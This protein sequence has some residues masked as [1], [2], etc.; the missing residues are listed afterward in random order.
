[1][2]QSRI[3]EELIEINA[4]LDG[5]L[6]ISGTV[7]ANAG[8]DLNTSLLALES[9]GNLADIKTSVELIDDTVATLGTN[10]YTEATTKGLIIGAVR[11]D[12]GGSLVDTDNEIA[13][14]QV[15]SNG[16]LIVSSGAGMNVIITDVAFTTTQ[17]DPLEMI[18]KRLNTDSLITNDRLRVQNMRLVFDSHFSIDDEPLVWSYNNISGTSATQTYDNANSTVNITT[19][20]LASKDEFVSKRPINISGGNVLCYITYRAWD[21]EPTGNQNRVMVGLGTQ[22]DG[23]FYE[24]RGNNVAEFFIR[25]NNVNVFSVSKGAW[26]IDAGN[27]PDDEQ[28][29]TVVFDFNPIVGRVR[30]GFLINGEISYKTEHFQDNMINEWP[31][32]NYLRA[33]LE[34][35]ADGLDPS[36]ITQLKEFKLFQED[37]CYI[38]PIYRSMFNTTTVALASGSTYAIAGIIFKAGLIKF[39]VVHIDSVGI[40]VTSASDEWLVSIQLDPTLAGAPAY[41]D[42]T[43]SSIRTL[44]LSNTHTVTGGTIIYSE[45]MSNNAGGDSVTFLKIPKNNLYLYDTGQ[46]CVCV[47]PISISVNASALLN[48]TEE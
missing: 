15:N 25:S 26:N 13:P 46:L 4:E 9:G 1:M 47:T 8:T 48:W 39:P 11:N 10:T 6:T 36:W 33:C 43:N 35:E 38:L 40:L 37:I 30:F 24:T 27:D 28:F 3:L 16:E 44:D 32:S 2:S 17:T 5:T 29:Q 23:Y 31:S 7:T 18:L 14:L 19:A 42:Q 20:L 22:R 45:Y 21:V 34:V 12:G 41:T